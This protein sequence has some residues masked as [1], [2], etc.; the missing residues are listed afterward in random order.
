MTPKMCTR[1][2]ASRMLLQMLLHLLHMPDSAGHMA[3]ML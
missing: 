3:T 1:A 2:T